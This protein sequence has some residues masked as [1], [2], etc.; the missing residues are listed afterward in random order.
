MDTESDRKENRR[1]MEGS[2]SI[3]G[4]KR[5]KREGKRERD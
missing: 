3:R 1:K 5:S 4:E 2:Y